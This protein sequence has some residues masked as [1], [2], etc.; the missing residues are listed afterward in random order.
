MKKLALLRKI[1]ERVSL[2][3]E[4]N[5]DEWDEENEKEIKQDVESSIEQFEKLFFELEETEEADEDMYQYVMECLVSG[6]TIAAIME[7]KRKIEEI[8]LA[9]V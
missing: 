9:K 4:I 3:Y 5:W 2:E 7:R 1:A 8:I 6:Y